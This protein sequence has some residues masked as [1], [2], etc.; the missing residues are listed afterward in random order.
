VERT[1]KFSRVI[2]GKEN[3]AELTL[4]LEPLKRGFGNR[5][6]CGV[7]NRGHIPDSVFDAVERGVN[8]ALAS[9]IVLGYPCI[10]IGVSLTGIE[11]AELSGTEFA[12]E[13]CASMGFDEAARMAEPFLLEPIMAVELFSPK[14][15]VGDVISLVTQRGGQV[16]S[17][18]TKSGRDVVKA[19]APMAKMF[20]F[21]TSLRS[22]SQGR[23]TFSME[24]AHFEKKV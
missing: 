24:F 3:A 10:D 13:A 14:E 7:K 17:M 18:E 15:F 4:R 19:T 6:A 9:G 1:E 16:L 21:M 2:A 22:V 5:Y 8:G 20:G 11:Y 12:Y 23:A